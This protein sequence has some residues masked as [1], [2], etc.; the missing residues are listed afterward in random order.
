MK[1]ILATM[2]IAM[3]CVHNSARSQLAE[4]VAR[5]LAAPGVTVFSAGSEPSSLRP[6]VTTVLQAHGLSSAG[7]YSKGL[8]AIP[9][10][11]MDLIITLCAEERCPALPPTAVSI[12]WALPEP[13]HL[14]GFQAAYEQIR[15]RVLGL[16]EAQ[17]VIDRFGL[18]RHPEGGWFK[19]TWRHQPTDPTVRGSGT[20]ILFLLRR[21]EA[22]H[23]HRVDATEA[24]LFNAGEP[25][26]LETFSGEARQIARMG[27]DVPGG[28]H[29]QVI[30]PPHVWQRARPLGEWTLVSCTVSPAFDFEG[31]ELAAPGWEPD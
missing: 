20:A 22:S 30:I 21:G 2:K 13:D 29:P 14:S 5:S 26:E 23:W 1:I 4:A 31:F 16:F 6:E 27:P 28:D 7:L 15:Q 3:L 24:W 9:L 17:A 19:E 25:L 18:Q 11:E 12:S 10:A 8:D